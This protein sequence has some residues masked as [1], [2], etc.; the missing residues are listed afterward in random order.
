MVYCMPF[1]IPLLLLALE[2]ES[3]TQPFLVGFLLYTLMVHKPC[4]QCTV[5]YAV[6]AV[7]LCATAAHHHCVVPLDEIGALLGVSKLGCSG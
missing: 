6:T 1:F 5:L 3:L 2:S 4:L 7:S